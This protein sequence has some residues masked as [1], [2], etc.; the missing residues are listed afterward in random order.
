MN[1]TNTRNILKALAIFFI[2]S[3][4]AS[5][6]TAATTSTPKYYASMHKVSVLQSGKIVPVVEVIFYEDRNGQ[7][8]ESVAA[9]KWFERSTASCTALMTQVIKYKNTSSA[10]KKTPALDKA[11]WI[12]KL[13]NDHS[14]STRIRF[15]RI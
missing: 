8:S 13:R 10:L 6:A 1:Q 11:K 5:M 15:V 3:L 14:K 9:K 7:G 4:G 12:K 2:I